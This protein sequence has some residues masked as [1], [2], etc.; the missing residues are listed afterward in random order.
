MAAC[1]TTHVL[2]SLMD[3]EVNALI[4]SLLHVILSPFILGLSA[5]DPPSLMD[6]GVRAVT[7]RERMMFW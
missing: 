7:S 2:T 6:R 5:S 3:R 4:M 1:A